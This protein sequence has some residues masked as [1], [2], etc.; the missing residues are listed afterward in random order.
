MGAVA[1]S[2][3]KTTTVAVTRNADVPTIAKGSWYNALA[4]TLYAE[5]VQPVNDAAS[6]SVEKRRGCE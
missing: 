4:G 1:T 3:I 2:Y 6:H 5:Y